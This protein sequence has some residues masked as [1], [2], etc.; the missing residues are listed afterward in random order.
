MDEID[1]LLADVIAEGEPPGFRDALLGG[2]LLE[3]RRRRRARLVGRPVAALAVLCLAGALAWLG[4]RPGRGGAS[5]QGPTWTAVQTRP[6]AAG[7][8]V[9]SRPMAAACLVASAPNAHLVRTAPGGGDYRVLSDDELLALIG[10]RGAA[11]VR[12]GP[13]SEELIFAD[14]DDRNGFPMN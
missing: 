3:A 6:L 9:T 2:M 5:A 11:L 12:V 14:P 10:S 13:N 7:S 1:R 8:L 4:S